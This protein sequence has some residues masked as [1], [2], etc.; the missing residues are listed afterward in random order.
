MAKAG[1]PKA[2]KK[3]QKV[4]SVR[5]LPEQYERLKQYADSSNITVTQAVLNRIADIIEL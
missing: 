5:V 2:E 1:R 4:I 3:K